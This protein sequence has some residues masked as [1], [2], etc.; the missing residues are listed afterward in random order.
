MSA[1][2][3]NLGATLNDAYMVKNL[4]DTVPTQYY[5]VIAGIEQFYDLPTMPF[6]EAV[7]RLKTFE[8]R[9]R[10]T[11]LSGK[12]GSQLL[13]EK[14]PALLL[15]A[16]AKRENRALLSKEQTNART[17]DGDGPEGDT[18][19]FDNGASNHMTG[20][21]KHFRHLDESVQGEVK[22]GAESKFQSKGKLLYYSIS[23]ATSSD[24]SMREQTSD[25]RGASMDIQLEWDPDHEDQGWLWNARLGHVNFEALRKLIEKKMVIGVP[26]ITRPNQ[27]CQGCLITK[28][29]RQPF[30]T[31]TRYRAKKALELLHANLCGPITPSKQPSFMIRSKDQACST[32]KNFKQQ[33]ETAS[34]Y[35]VKKLRTDYG[36]IQRHLTA[37]YTPQHNGVVERRNQ[38]VMVM[39]RSLLETMH[40]QN[41]LLREAMRHA[42]YI[43]NRLPT[44]ALEIAHHLRYGAERSQTS[45]I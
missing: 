13:K 24:Y 23:R 20:E 32:F 34:G 30:P 3:A 8:K 40:V 19:Y 5:Q 21:R 6:E 17:K 16:A 45:L 15:S 4:F 37:P 35:R 29:P 27:L 18:W 28:Q 2:Y 42:V 43:L 25:G 38:T 9:I 12:S 7:R 41:E 36:G 22:F 10:Q 31:Q 26:L 1:K 14:E 11:T 33:V 44:K 39:A